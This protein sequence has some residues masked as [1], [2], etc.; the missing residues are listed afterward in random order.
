MIELSVKVSNDEQTLTQKH[1]VY[2]TVTLS[3]DDPTLL[4]LVKQAKEAFGENVEDVV[5]KIKMTW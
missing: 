2:E 1:M 3:V 4:S 5:L